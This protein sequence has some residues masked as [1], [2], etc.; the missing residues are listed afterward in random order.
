MS[1]FYLN[2]TQWGNKILFRGISDGQRI[3]SKDDFQPTLYVRSP[4]KSEYKT[5]FEESLKPIHFDDINAAKGFIKQYEDVGDFPIF[6]NTYF[7]YQYISEKYEDAINYDPALIR[8][9]SIDIETEIE[10]GFPNSQLA[11]EKILLITIKNRNTK[12]IDTFGWKDFDVTKITHFDASLYTYHKS[13]NE[14]EMLKMFLKFWEADT[15]DVVTGWNIRY[16]DIPYIVNRI[17]KVL[18]E[19]SEVRLSPWRAVQEKMVVENNREQQVFDLVGIS[20]LDYIEVYRKYNPSKRAENYKLD[21]IAFIE[22]GKHKLESSYETF[23]E[24][25]EK[26][27]QLFVEYNCVDTILVDELEDRLRLLEL[28]FLMAYRAKSNFSDV[29]SPVR[30]WDCLIY[31]E[32]RSQKIAPPQAR[33]LSKTDIVGGY[34]RQPPPGRYQSVVSMDATSLYP[35][36]MMGLNM[37]PETI[38]Q[39]QYIPK[40]TVE[41]FL[42]KEYDMTDAV[43]HDVAVA[44][45]GYAFTRKKQGFL[46]VLIERLFDERVSIKKKQLEAERLYEETKNETYKNEAKKMKLA[47][48]GI[49]ILL[50]SCFGGLA[51]NYFRWSDTRIAEG[52]TMTGQYIIQQVAADIDAYM[53][54]I[55]GTHNQRYVF[56]CDTDSSYITLHPLVEQFVPDAKGHQLIDILDTICKEKLLPVIKK[57]CSGIAQYGNFYRNTTE[58][59]RELIAD[60][61]IFTV[62]K[63]YA[64]S[65]WNSE[66]VVLTE[67]QIKIVGMESNRSSTPAWCRQKFKDMMKIC[68]TGT[69]KELWAFMKTTAAEY[70]LL[71][72]EVIGTP[73]PASGLT[74]YADNNTIYIKGTPIQT[75]CALLHNHLLKEKK[76]TKKFELLHEGDKI[77][78]VYLI[79]PNPLHE[80]AFGWSGKLPEE[81]GLHRYI[82]Y[83]TMYEK[84]FLAPVE[85]VLD[86]IKW[87]FKRKASI[88]AFSNLHT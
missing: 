11:G 84:T 17:V 86:A 53:N 45:N 83:D 65:V 27:W 47:Q 66:G 51:N 82:D 48:E 18:P 61:A 9:S 7:Q 20:T 5:L 69:E 28:V 71:P 31:N 67:P 74:K 57:S 4:A 62:K 79:E 60:Q 3:E 26:D 59:K 13:R 39:K 58:F 32:L 33:K 77:K 49:K 68:L 25:Y 73:K 46:P 52:I 12:H 80:D 41:G 34:V 38:V 54:K 42:A 2:A 37:S 75:R 76:L 85:S 10:N 16:F 50:N 56:Y 19:R 1:N 72:P 64:L 87:S 14:E 30:L 40:C 81:F 43:I 35:R 55:C 6:G 63:R 29:F 24:F 22:L 15:P 88:I 44:A 21:T 78:I 70:R 36:I 8:I 23:K